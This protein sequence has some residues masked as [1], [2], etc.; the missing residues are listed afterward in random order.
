M[1]EGVPLALLPVACEGCADAIFG[2]PRDRNPYHPL[3]AMDAYAAWEWGF[4]E[5]AHLLQTRG[6][7]E[8]A[9]WLR[10]VA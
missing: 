9:R 2:R 4:D 6:R 8:A 5:G 1:T 7:E 10:E 3:A